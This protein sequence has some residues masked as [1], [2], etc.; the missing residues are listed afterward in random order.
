M[1]LLLSGQRGQTVC[2][3]DTRNITITSDVVTIRIGDIVK[4]TRPGKHPSELTF[5]ANTPNPRL[6]IVHTL[7][8]Y[9]LRTTPIRQGHTR[10][11]L[12]YIKPYKPVGRGTIS[13]WVKEVSPLV[14]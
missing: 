2:L 6:C 4:Q 9:L 11:F 8:M 7:Q 13:R 3:C 1:L 12:S 14:A 5:P 10:L